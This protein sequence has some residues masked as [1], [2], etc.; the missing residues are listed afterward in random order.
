MF[1][2][3]RFKILA[4]LMATA[5]SYADSFSQRF[6]RRFFVGTEWFSTCK[7]SA[8]YL[9]DTIDLIQYRNK[10]SDGA[11]E[12]YA[13]RLCDGYP[14]V[15]VRFKK[16][17]RLDVLDVVG[18]AYYS[19]WIGTWTFDRRRNEMLLFWRRTLTARFTPLKIE[20]L[21]VPSGAWGDSLLKTKRLI[22]V[23]KE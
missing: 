17:E 2:P 15:N 3:R 14:H 9:A 23:R 4:I 5:F 11:G 21:V 12:F 7:D 22:L 10:R 13:E 6:S 1:S 20:D 16:K 19:G 18:C 8:F